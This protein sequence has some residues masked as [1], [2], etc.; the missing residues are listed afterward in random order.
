MRKGS[1]R[2]L[3]LGSWDPGPCRGWDDRFSIL[4]AADTAECCGRAKNKV[5][6]PRAGS[7]MEPKEKGNESPWLALSADWLGEDHA[8]KRR[9][10]SCGRL[11]EAH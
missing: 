6:A 7:S 3:R 10:V 2:S 5:G 1:L 4:G 8:W 9:E 11:D